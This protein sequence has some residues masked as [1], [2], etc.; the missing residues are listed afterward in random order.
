MDK[1]FL[2]T[3]DPEL[4]K[5]AWRHAKER[6]PVNRRFRFAAEDEIAEWN[7]RAESYTRKAASEASQSL[8]ESILEWLTSAG[9]LNRNFTAIDIGAG[10][11][12]FS[13]PLASQLREIWALEPAREM[14]KIL[15]IR[16][17]EAGLDNIRC[18]GE[19]WEEVIPERA[20]WIE[21]F[22]LV[23]A[24][25]SPGISNPEAL[26]KMNRVSRKFCYL[27]T[28]SGPYW[29]NWGKAKDDIWHEM[30]QEDLG[31]YPNDILYAFGLLY[32]EGYRPE[33]R[34]RQLESE[35]E[36]DSRKVS[37][38]LIGLFSQYTEITSREQGLIEE[39]V[40]HHSTGGVFSQSWT[41]SQGFMLWRA[42]RRAIRV[43]RTASL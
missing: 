7:Q 8:R 22:D 38:E 36:E 34:F 14:I 20:G 3:E 31:E 2:P 15:K 35:I 4:W 42:D 21:K 24:S 26:E 23:F 17:S 28:W 27:S 12:S 10:P 33:I 32:S 30:F 1:P 43:Q 37:D 9:A 18:T 6:S 40:S 25:M 19:K 41:A 39:Y 13:I 16:L 5:Q 11:G 29:G